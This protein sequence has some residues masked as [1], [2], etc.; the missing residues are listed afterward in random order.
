MNKNLLFHISVSGLHNKLQYN[1]NLH[2][3]YRRR[4]GAGHCS[5][6]RAGVDWAHGGRVGDNRGHRDKTGP[7]GH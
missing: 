1:Y 3:E 7:G 5:V 4:R 6:R 2:V